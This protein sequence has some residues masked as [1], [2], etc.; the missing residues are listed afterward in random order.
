M[1]M[2]MLMMKR[3]CMPS[4]YYPEKRVQISKWEL[5]V[6]AGL[7]SRTIQKVYHVLV[8]PRHVRESYRWMRTVIKCVYDHSVQK[9]G[10][11]S[12]CCKSPARYLPVIK[13]MTVSD[14]LEDDMDVMNQK[15]V[16]WRNPWERDKLCSGSVWELYDNAQERYQEYLQH[17]EPIFMGMLRRM[18]LLEK[19][20]SRAE[21]VKD[22][23]AAQIP[24]TVKTLENRN[25][26]SGI[27]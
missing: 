3:E 22:A 14:Y 5:A 23:L 27:N 9:S 7:L 6:I 19:R 24:E 25:Y 20:Q 8:K 10:K 13:N 12:C 26:H 15:T 18:L 1:D 16:L 4:S 11:K 17:M 21:C 2:H